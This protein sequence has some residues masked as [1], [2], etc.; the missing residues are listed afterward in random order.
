MPIRPFRS[1][2]APALAALAV[3]CARGEADFVLNP[4]WETADELEAEFAR[5]GIRPE[6]HVL[7]A[8]EG[9]G[10][11]VQGIVGF[12]RRPKDPSA[13]MVGPIVRRQDRGRGLG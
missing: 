6:E 12:L 13:G 2:D 10:G 9:D 7:V 4:I 8:D 1:A 3:E 5:F 11:E